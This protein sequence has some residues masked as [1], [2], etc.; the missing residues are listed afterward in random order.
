MLLNK[1]VHLERFYPN[2]LSLLSSSLAHQ[3]T[4]QA[5]SGENMYSHIPRCSGHPIPFDLARLV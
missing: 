3:R 4:A 5:G 2:V 1:D